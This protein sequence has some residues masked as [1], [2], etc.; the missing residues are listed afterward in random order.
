MEYLIQKRIDKIEEKKKRIDLSKRKLHQN[1][2]INRIEWI[3]RLLQTPIED[4]R[5]QCLWRILCPYLI[6]IRKVT[7]EEALKILQ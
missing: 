2:Q 3:E 4:Y 6:N 1:S 7:D 5:K